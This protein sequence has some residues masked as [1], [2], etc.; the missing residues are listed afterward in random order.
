MA[1]SLS[2]VRRKLNLI[3]VSVPRVD[4]VES[5]TFKYATNFDTSLTTIQTIPAAGFASKSVVLSEVDSSYDRGRTTKFIFCPSDYSI[6]DTK[7]IFLTV[8]VKQLGA[9]V[10]PDSAVH[11]VTPYSQIPNR[12]I[13]LKGSAKSAANISGSTE[14]QMPQ[15]CSNL[16][17]QVNGTNNVWVGFE[18]G[19]GEYRV[20]PQSLEF[21]NFSQILPVFTQLFVRAESADTAFSAVFSVKNSG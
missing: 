5:Y 17:M 14:I 4:N 6:D 13:I 2:I 21:L 10:G 11:L 19:G 20:A 18:Q 12:N 9:A 7:Q 16:N 1:R 3:S 8:A 15:Q